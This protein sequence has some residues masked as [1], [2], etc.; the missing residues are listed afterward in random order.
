MTSILF[1]RFAKLL[2]L[3]ILLTACL[4]DNSVN[5]IRT[6]VALVTAKQQGGVEQAAG[7]AFFIESP[8]DLCALLTAAHV[9]NGDNLR[10]RANDGQSW[11]VVNV[12]RIPKRDIAVLTF[13]PGQKRCPYQA[14]NLGNSQDI[15]ELDEV[16]IAGYPKSSSGSLNN[17]IMHVLPGQVSTIRVASPNNEGYS[18]AYA[19]STEGGNSGGPVI[20]AKTWKVVAVHGLGAPE[21]QR[22]EKIYQGAITVGDAEKSVVR[23]YGAGVRWGI[24]INEFPKGFKVSSVSQVMSAKEYVAQGTQLFIQGKYDKAL[25]IYEQAIQRASDSADAW[26]GKGSALFALKRYQEALSAYDTALKY[27]PKSAYAWNYGGSTQW[28]LGEF[29]KAFESFTK[30]TELMPNYTDAWYNRGYTAGNNLQQYQ[31]AIEAL[32]KAVQ[33]KPDYADA[34]NEK[35]YALY[36]IQRYSAAVEASE[37]AIQLKPDAAYYWFIKGMILGSWEQ[38][39][40]SIEANEKAIELFPNYQNAW[41]NKCWALNQLERY[42][43]ALEACERSREIDP[44]DRYPWVQRGFALEHL[45]SYQSALVAYEKARSLDPGNKNNEWI[46]TRVERIRKTL[47]Q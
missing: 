37:R 9:A 39:E 36:N 18:I 29:R 25:N 47:Q 40:R 34:W 4:H 21:L 2:L 43:D 1:S 33:L 31:D 5:R 45:N 10:I 3:S 11:T 44:N 12:Q 28:N 38:Y 27:N 17:P 23:T 24:P 8:E 14:L 46:K 30:A 32:D 20:N 13:D 6:S 41:D 19:S 7:T 35:A 22:L 42:K 26:Q 16:L 15:Q